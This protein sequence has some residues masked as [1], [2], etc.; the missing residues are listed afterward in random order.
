MANKLDVFSED[1]YKEILKEVGPFRYSIYDP[2][3]LVP[4]N[5]FSKALN[6]ENYNCVVA[7]TG[8]TLALCALTLPDS[9]R[10][11]ISKDSPVI[12]VRLLR[13][14]SSHGP[15]HYNADDQIITLEEMLPHIRPGGIYLCE[16]LKRYLNGFSIYLE[17]LA[18]NLNAYNPVKTTGKAIVKPTPFQKAVGSMHFYPFVAVIEKN[19]NF[20]DQL[21]S[22]KHGTEWQLIP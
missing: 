13:E 7:G 5:I 19:L 20:I 1:S 4:G 9:R 16:D 6:L 18:L 15:L 21:E 22:V 8:S 11:V 14:D 10:I 3:E 2:G 17:G 12:V